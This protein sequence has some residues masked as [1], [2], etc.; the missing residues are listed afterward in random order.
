M[1]EIL[2]VVDLVADSGFEGIVTWLVR[3]VGLV[4]LLGGLGLW[5]FTDMGLLVVPAVLLLVGLVL[6]VAP[7]V[8]LLAAELA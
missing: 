4:A 5:L 6:L 7:S 3:F 8:L 1:D 2:D